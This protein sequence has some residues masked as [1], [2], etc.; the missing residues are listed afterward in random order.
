MRSSSFP[1]SSG[2][3]F[4]N[5]S[6]RIAING[7]ANRKAVCC[8]QQSNV[9]GLWIE[10]DD[11]LRTIDHHIL[12]FTT[13]HSLLTYFKSQILLSYRTH[14]HHPSLHVLRFSVRKQDHHHVYSTALLSFSSYL[15]F[16]SRKESTV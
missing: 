1:H 10:M 3:A 9:Q 6:L 5:G 2:I 7:L 15:I 14:I 4:I 8:Q 16:H 12:L 11:R 13:H